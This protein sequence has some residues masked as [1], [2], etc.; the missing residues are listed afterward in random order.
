MVPLVNNEEVRTL[1]AYNRWANRRLLTTARLLPWPDF[2]RDLRSSHGS[3]R[4]TLVHIIW[5]EWLWTR[6]WQGESPTQVFAPEDFH[7]W[8]TLDSRWKMVEN[9]QQTFLKNLNDQLSNIRVSYENLQGQRWEY[10]LVH[11][12]QHC[13]N[14]SSYHRGHVAA[15]LRQL[16]QT[17]PAT[18]FLVFL[19]E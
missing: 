1:Y 2:I 19:D 5:A 16:G 6:R 11:M 9:E 18:D 8:A 15:L 10:S 7:D 14:H 4:G 17:P 12:L 13:I 3:L